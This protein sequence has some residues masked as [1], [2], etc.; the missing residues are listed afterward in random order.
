ML[1][2]TRLRV[3]NSLP[4]R[5]QDYFF[6]AIRTLC[7][8]HIARVSRGRSS[9]DRDAEALELISE[10]M[11]KLLGVATIGTGQSLDHDE[12]KAT[13]RELLVNDDPKRD[14]RIAWLIDEVGGSQALTH[15]YEDIRRRRH[16]GKW[17]GDGYRQVQLNE[18]HIS[19][20]AVD[21]D[22]PHYE[23]DTRQIWLGLLT[24]AETSFKADDDVSVLLNIM[25]HDADIQAGFG[26]E[27]PI[28]QIVNALK[29]RHPNQPWNDDRVENAKK[30]LKNWISRLKREN[31]LDSSDLMDLFA[32]YGRNR[33]RT[34]K[35]SSALAYRS[36]GAS[37]AAS[38]ELGS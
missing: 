2:A 11:A 26:S 28:R 5:H 6:E 4:W 3:L 15:R 10:V 37:K 9:A 25:A 17:Q 1:G 34:D 38:S 32:R 36:P 13:P 35:A 22:D 29:Q 24:A 31:G 7:T 20:L 14:G 23:S 33:Q 8:K 30:R 18:D 12:K 16:G 27:W 21:P 19:G